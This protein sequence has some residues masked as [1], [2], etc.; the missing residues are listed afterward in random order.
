ME[1]EDY[2]FYQGLVYLLEH[3]IDE[4]GVEL[5]LSTDVS[6]LH[7]VHTFR[8]IQGA[9]WQRIRITLCQM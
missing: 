2:S 7:N 5:T 9:A 8:H 4:F 6:R 3:D 1:A